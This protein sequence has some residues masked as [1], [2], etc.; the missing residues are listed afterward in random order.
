MQFNILFQFVREKKSFL[1]VHSPWWIVIQ[2][3]NSFFWVCISELFKIKW[4]CN[5]L[6]KIEYERHWP[7]YFNLTFL[8]INS[9]KASNFPSDTWHNTAVRQTLNL[10]NEGDI[11]SETK[12]IYYVLMHLSICSSNFYHISP[13]NI[14]GVKLSRVKHVLARSWYFRVDVDWEQLA[15]G[16]AG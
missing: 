8:W 11:N 13:T 10:L 2:Q 9:L 12:F 7:S 3:L 5:F 15:A 1:F 16:R 4:F 14:F 6:L